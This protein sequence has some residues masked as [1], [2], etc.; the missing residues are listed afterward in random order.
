MWGGISF[1]MNERPLHEMDA[2]IKKAKISLLFVEK[3]ANSWLLSAFSA[4]IRKILSLFSL[5]PHPCKGLIEL[6]NNDLRNLY[7]TPS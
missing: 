3:L 2:R 5:A 1:I 4:S 7:A 6:I